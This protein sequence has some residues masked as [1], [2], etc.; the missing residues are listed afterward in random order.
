MESSITTAPMIKR[1]FISHLQNFVGSLGRLARQPFA[2]VLTCLVLAVALALPAGLR[3]FVNNADVLSNS[4]ESVADLTVFLEFS[5]DENAAIEVADRV[6]AREDVDRVEFITRD[7]AL[8]E[9]RA[10]SGFADALDALEDNPLPHTLVVRPATDALT[11]V[12]ILAADLNALEEIQFVQIDT[13]WVERLRA[14]LELGQRFV[15]IAT[16]LLGLG[17]L[18]VIGNTIRLEINNRREE[19][20]VMKLVGGS[21]G[22]IRRPFLYLGLWYGL[23]GALGAAALIGLTLLLLRAPVAT[24]ASLYGSQFSLAGLQVSELGVLVGLGALLG[25]A[26]AGLAAARHL[27]AIEPT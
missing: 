1:Y 27:R 9:F 8:E 5:I 15:D 12:E 3:V 26:G 13:A 23:F 7:D 14:M 19:I 11:S 24:L 4:W 25:W 2:A 10:R 20:V 22:F 16:I 18:V 17:V 6:Q 21:D